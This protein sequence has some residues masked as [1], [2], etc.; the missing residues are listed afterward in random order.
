M[1]TDHNVVY[2]TGLNSYTIMNGMLHVLICQGGHQPLMLF[3]QVT[4]F[5]NKSRGN[6]YV[7]SEFIDDCRPSTTYTSRPVASVKPMIT[8]PVPMQPKSVLRGDNRNLPV[9]SKNKPGVSVHKVLT[10]T[11]K[12]L[13]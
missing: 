3:A 1:C 12:S 11:G 6:T 2:L 5:L 13:L 10:T 7:K 9:V 8:T 4:T